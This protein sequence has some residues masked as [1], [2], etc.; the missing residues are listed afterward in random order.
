MADELILE[1]TY[2][3]WKGKVSQRRISPVSIRIGTT[4][5]HPEPGALL[6]AKDM[7]KNEMREFALKDCD[8]L[9]SE[10]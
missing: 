1:M 9:S 6:L 5:W 8:F 7:D 3:N 10:V 4:E 2:R